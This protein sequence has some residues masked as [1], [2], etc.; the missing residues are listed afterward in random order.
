MK[1]LITGGAGYK[2]T[3]L[4]EMLLERGYDV[5]ILDNF[6][7]GFDSVLSFVHNKNCHIIRKDIRNLEVQDVSSYDV[8]FHL[9][10]ISGYPACEAN[11]HTAEIVNVYATQKM[12]NFL[13]K[14]QFLIYAS[15]TSFYGNTGAIMDEESAVNP[16][17]LYG[18][19]K[20]EG[21]K[22]CMNHENAISLRFATLFGLSYRMRT[23]LLVNDFVKK[24]MKDR[25][26]V[27]FDSTSIR[28]Y[29]HVRD[30]ISSYV[31]ALENLELMKGEIF[32]V[33]SND[34]N[35]SKKDLAHKIEKHINYKIID[36]DLDDF[37]KRNFIINYDKI[38]KLG[39]KPKFSI[40]DG[41]VELKKLYSF[42]LSNSKS[43][44]L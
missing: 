41:I 39:F 10:G 11:P 13:H 4:T 9:A 22:I 23:D 14:D 37:D 19:T 3:I 1:I 18:R 42:Y 6:Y 33:G 29:L 17:S 2:G 5:T 21:E 12:V 15:T 35:F 34:M 30:A 16:I 40:D 36:S 24:A 43:Y 8:I 26:L 38:N 27:L 44:C 25:N 32:N 28:T 31:L 7:I 20:Y